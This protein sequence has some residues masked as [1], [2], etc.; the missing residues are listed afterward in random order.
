MNRLI[1]LLSIFLIFTLASSCDEP[2]KKNSEPVAE[3]LEVSPDVF[4]FT[5][6]AGSGTFRITN[7]SDWTMA[8]N[9]DWLTFVPSSGSGSYEGVILKVTAN[10]QPDIRTGVLTITSSGGLTARINVTQ[11]G[12]NPYIIINPVSAEVSYRGED[13]TVNVTSSYP[14][15][16]EKP[17]DADWI[18]LKPS[19]ATQ[20]KL[21]VAENELFEKRSAIL[22]FKLVDIDGVQAT[23]KLDQLDKPSPEYDEVSGQGVIGE[24]ITITGDRIIQTDEV[25]FGVWKGV[26]TSKTDVSITVTIPE[27]AQ[28]GKTV[29]KVVYGDVTETIGEIELVYKEIEPF[30][31][32]SPSLGSIGKTITLAGT[33]LNEITNFYFGSLEGEIA[34]DRTNTS[35]KVTIPA[36]AESADA[37]QMK[38][39]YGRA[40]KEKTVGTISIKYQCDK[41]F[42]RWNGDPDIPYTVWTAVTYDIENLW[43]ENLN[44]IYNTRANMTATPPAHGDIITFD[45]GATYQLEILRWWH[46]SGSAN[47]AIVE[48]GASVSTPWMFRGDQPKIFR[49]YGSATPDALKANDESESPENKWI[50][51][52]EYE[53]FKPSGLP[54][55]EYTPE[56]ER[57]ARVDGEEFIIEA[58][59]RTPVRYIRIDA[60]V[61]WGL[62]G[63][64][65]TADN[66]NFHVAEMSFWGSPVK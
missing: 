16:M 49:L 53:S 15:T 64:H 19:N 10:N 54:Y 9:Q 56:D 33:D 24:S 65:S 14:W 37:A 39:V 31:T 66:K 12:L 46:R 42:V 25:W 58:S 41:P 26:I 60:L 51:L 35:M 34:A 52:G 3:V 32:S 21:T 63:G 43:D 59:K 13:V 17:D 38:I 47:V 22:T 55:G 62:V 23:M 61:N 30:V 40:A 48:G 20:A 1:N 6:V 11:G 18:T 4:S 29:V 44:N 36:T 27:E 45:L 7:N 8:S 28:A 2:D 5:R 50:L 57:V